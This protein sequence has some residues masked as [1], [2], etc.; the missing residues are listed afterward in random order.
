MSSCLS[1]GLAVTITLSSGE[2][3]DIREVR[4]SGP[5]GPGGLLDTVLLLSSPGL[6]SMSQ[7]LEPLLKM[8]GWDWA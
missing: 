4:Q 8:Q 2:Q 7:N 1:Q 3:M 5:W 6:D